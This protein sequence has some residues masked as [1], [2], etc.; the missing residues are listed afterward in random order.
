[1]LDLSVVNHLVRNLVAL[2]IVSLSFSLLILGKYRIAVSLFLMALTIH[3]FVVIFI[4]IYLIYFFRDKLNFRLIVLL[5]ILIASAVGFYPVDYY[6]SFM[7]GGGLLSR[8]YEYQYSIPSEYN[9]RFY[10]ERLIFV[11]TILS[12][13]FLKGGRNIFMASV[14]FAYYIS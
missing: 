8:A 6:L 3:F 12:V 4:V 9:W 13:L 10:Y 7:G 11:V 14:I 2:S 5:M 1:G